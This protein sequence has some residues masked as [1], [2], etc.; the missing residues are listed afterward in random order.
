VSNWPNQCRSGSN[1][2]SPPTGRDAAGSCPFGQNLLEL[3]HGRRPVGQLALA[4]SVAVSVVHLA[5]GQAFDL[6]PAPDSAASRSSHFGAIEF[7]SRWLQDHFLVP[8]HFVD[9]RHL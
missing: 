5:S 8:V 9:G 4:K 3:V 1:Q 2:G 6:V 7:G